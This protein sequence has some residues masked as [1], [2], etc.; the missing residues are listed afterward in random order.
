M[1]DDGDFLSTDCDSIARDFVCSRGKVI[2]LNH[3]SVRCT[4]SMTE[5]SVTVPDLNECTAGFCQ[6]G[7]N[8]ENF[9]RGY[10]CICPAGW[11]GDNC[12]EGYIVLKLIYMS[13]HYNPIFAFI[14][15]F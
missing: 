5:V 2:H 15:S 13:I 9:D 7:A 3:W 4:F 11:T 14:L 6:N 8:C 1:R 12:T 10:S